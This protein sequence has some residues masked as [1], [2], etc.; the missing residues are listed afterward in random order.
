MDLIAHGGHALYDHPA[1]MAISLAAL[2]IP[3]CVLVVVGRLFWRASKD[4]P[5][6]R[7]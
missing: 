3:M 6:R 2:I 7:D 4:D 1:M 5:D